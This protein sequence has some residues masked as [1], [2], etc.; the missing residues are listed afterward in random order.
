MGSPVVNSSL[1]VSGPSTTTGAAC[2]WSFAVMNRPEVTPRERTTFQLG[3]VPVSV[4][5]QLVDPLT[6]D[7]D[8]VEI[9]ATAWMS[10]AAALDWSARAS[11]TVN[12]D[13]EPN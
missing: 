5:V 9:G 4:V 8:D 2:A 1:A 3:V 13:A 11:W 7:T 6:S 10:G 12:V